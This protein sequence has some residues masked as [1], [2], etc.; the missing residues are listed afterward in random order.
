MVMK[1]YTLRK[2]ISSP[3]SVFPDGIPNAKRQNFT[4]KHKNV[5]IFWFNDYS[6]LSSNQIE[7]SGHRLLKSQEICKVVK[8]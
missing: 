7:Y 2:L 5:I 8:K 1:L 6:A 3:P 4:I